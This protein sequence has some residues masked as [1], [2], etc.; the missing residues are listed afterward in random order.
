MNSPT[1]AFIIFLKWLKRRVTINVI[2]P[3]DRPASNLVIDNKPVKKDS[4]TTSLKLPTGLPITILFI[5]IFGFGIYVEHSL[6]VFAPSELSVEILSSQGVKDEAEQ[7]SQASLI[8]SETVLHQAEL[9]HQSL[10]EFHRSENQT[11][12]QPTDKLY[13][14]LWQKDYSLLEQKS[15]LNHTIR[16]LLKERHYSVAHLF[17][18]NLTQ[19]QRDEFGLQFSFAFSQAKLKQT[20]KAVNSYRQ[21]LIKRPNHQAGN[22]NL[23]Y[24]LLKQGQYQQAETHFLSIVDSMGGERKSKALV[25]VAKAQTGLGR[26][27]LAIK[28]YQRA[29]EYRPSLA[30]LWASLAVVSARHFQDLHAVNHRF[31]QATKLAPNDP[32]LRLNYAQFLIKALNFEEAT[33]QLKLARKL[34]RDNITIRLM[35]SFCYS[36]LGKKV[37]SAKQLRLAKKLIQRSSDKR[38]IEALELYLDKNW[39]DGLETFKTLLKKGRQNDLEYTMIASAYFNLNKKKSALLYLNKVES[40]SIYFNHG[41]LLYAEYLERR[42][43]YSAANDVLNRVALQLTDNP[44]VQFKAASFALNAELFDVAKDNIE[45]ALK[46]ARASET[47]L[48][49]RI[50]LKQAEIAWKSGNKETAI[51]QLD[52]LLTASPNYFRAY[53]RLASYNQQYGNIERAIEVYSALFNQRGSYS[54]VEYQ[55]AKLYFLKKQFPESQFLLERYIAANSGVKAPRLLLA[56]V[57]CEMGQSAE[58]EETLQWLLKLAPDYQPALDYHQNIM[59][60]RY[61]H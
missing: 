2:N 30:T 16:K 52:N 6:S 40:N 29:I 49:N 4:L 38:Q 7:S 17:L 57:F 5:L 1:S 9:L 28:S 39:R 35:L 26:F 21:L 54:D 47:G 23:G 50:F 31:I 58:C 20:P 51:T 53:Y 11:T 10:T 13:A 59:N 48:S 18:A 15:V 12:T 37:N 45:N 41:Q 3:T 42:K 32:I 56:R 22:L 43:Q 34:S 44:L 36:Q 27:E 60:N 25:G 24:L 8:E 19:Q 14:N 33:S 46:L 55:L 61:S